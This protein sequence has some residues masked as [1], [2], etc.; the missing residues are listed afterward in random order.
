MADDF[1][2]SKYYKIFEEE[3]NAF[4][5]EGKKIDELY[6]ESHTLFDRKLNKGVNGAMFGSSSGD[7]DAIE[8]SKS[9]CSI[10]QTKLSV[11]KEITN[12]KKTVSELNLKEKQQILESDEAKDKQ[13][14]IDILEALSKSGNR[15]SD[16]IGRAPTTEGIEMLD[17]D[18]I[19]LTAVDTEMVNRF[20]ENNK[21]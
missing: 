4:S 7:K 18:N 17:T 8:M 21:K 19:P 5:E 10:R 3:L 11:I 14:I 12:L 13:H 9:L 2:N 6:S 1:K 16:A 20:R 15:Y